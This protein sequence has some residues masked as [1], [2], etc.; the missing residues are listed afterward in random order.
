MALEGP[1]FV[2]RTW[3][4]G[5]DHLV[6]WDP[7]WGPA[8]GARARALPHPTFAAALIALDAAEAI[9]APRPWITPRNPARFEY[10]V[11]NLKA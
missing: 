5:D 3:T 1:F 2:R 9:C 6:G 11:H 4:A 7:I 10:S 8:W